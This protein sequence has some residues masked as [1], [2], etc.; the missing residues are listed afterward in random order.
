MRNVWYLKQHHLIFA[1]VDHDPVANV[2]GEMKNEEKC[3]DSKT[4]D[5]FIYFSLGYMEYILP[6][7]AQCF[8][9]SFYGGY[10]KPP[11]GPLGLDNWIYKTERYE[12]NLVV[13]GK[14]P[15][16]RVFTEIFWISP[17]NGCFMLFL[18]CLI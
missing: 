2:Y 15:W 7:Q 4:G 11:A 3:W 17:V 10:I 13:G 5:I 6:L 1:L 12:R 18:L 9:L 14:H 8:S 16:L